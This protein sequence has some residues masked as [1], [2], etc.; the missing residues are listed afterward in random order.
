MRTKLLLLITLAALVFA[1]CSKDDETDNIWKDNNYAAFTKTAASAEY[2]TI[3]SQSKNGSIAYKVIK[4]GDENGERA[5]YNDQ[6]KVLYTG[7]FKVVD[8]NKPNTFTDEEGLEITNKYVFDTT[9]NRNG[10]PSIFRVSGLIDGF[11]TALQYM[12]EGDKWEVWI[13]SR[14]G[15]GTNEQSNIPANTTLVFEIELLEVVKR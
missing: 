6:V 14:L 11:S 7:W 2:K 4:S 15:Y 9:D 10:Y 5:L 8:W 12:R 13:P 1:S 3:Q